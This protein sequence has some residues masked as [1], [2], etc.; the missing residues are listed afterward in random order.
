MESS[1]A[2]QSKTIN[3]KNEKKRLLKISFLLNLY[4]N[5]NCDQKKIS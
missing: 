2:N 3:I 4:Y 5:N 1:E